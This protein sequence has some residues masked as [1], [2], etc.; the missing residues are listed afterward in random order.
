MT[1]DAKGKIGGERQINGTFVGGSG[2]CAGMTGTSESTGITG[3]KPPKEG[4]TA[5]SSSGKFNWKIP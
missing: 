2:K 5:G 1:Y 3:I 4:M